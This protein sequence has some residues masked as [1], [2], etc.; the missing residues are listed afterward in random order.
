MAEAEVAI[1]QRQIAEL[2]AERTR[3]EEESVQYKLHW[4]YAIQTCGYLVEQR[5]AAV[6]KF[7]ALEKGVASAYQAVTDS[8][9]SG[10]GKKG[11]INKHDYDQLKVTLQ[12]QIRVA[13]QLEE[14]RDHANDEYEFALARL[15]TVQRHHQKLSHAASEMG[16][17]RDR[18]VAELDILR[19]QMTQG[20]QEESTSSTPSDE[21]SPGEHVRLSL[22]LSEDSSTTALTPSEK[23]DLLLLRNDIAKLR[24]QLNDTEKE[25]DELKAELETCFD[26][27][28][29]F[30]EN[31]DQARKDCR[32]SESIVHL[33]QKKY[34]KLAKEKMDLRED[35]LTA[36]DRILYL[37]DELAKERLHRKSFHNNLRV[38]PRSQ[39]TPPPRAQS[40]E[41]LK[42]DETAQTI[43]QPKV[44]HH[45]SYDS[46]LDSQLSYLTYGTSDWDLVP[47]NDD[48]IS[49]I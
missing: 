33:W 38:S 20:T 11:K 31:M 25:R 13:E 36:N 26:Q 42:V 8:T 34:D 41:E 23:D 43:P 32:A 15:H 46:L 7:E 28:N 30:E 1:L 19:Q 5:N 48:E 49:W 45:G 40:C 2:I 22:R 17:E 27:L 47:V 9:S 24:E 18:A 21:K 35:L 14:E 6:S 10:K 12:T 39:A 37:Q 4:T 44:E 16:R 3:L 29:Q